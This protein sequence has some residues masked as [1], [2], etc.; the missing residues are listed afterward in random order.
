MKEATT[1]PTSMYDL[2]L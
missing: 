2:S 1:S